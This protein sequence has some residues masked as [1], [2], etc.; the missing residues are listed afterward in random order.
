MD[1]WSSAHCSGAVV[2]RPEDDAL[3]ISTETERSQSE[4]SCGL[5][6]RY[7]RSRFLPSRRNTGAVSAGQAELSDVNGALDAEPGHAAHS[8]VGRGTRSRIRASAFAAG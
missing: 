3:W 6:N 2:R 4:G 7:P 8:V 5:D 1:H